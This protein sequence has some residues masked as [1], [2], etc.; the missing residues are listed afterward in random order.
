M[1][2]SFLNLTSSPK[3]KDNQW[4]ANCFML[5]SNNIA[6]AAYKS[7][8]LSSANW[9][10]TDTRIGGNVAIN[11]PPAYTRFADPRASGL[12]QKNVH[13]TRPA[14]L[15]EY[16]SDQIDANAQI[17]HMQFGV[18]TFRGMLSF[19]AGVS[20]IKAGL[21]ARTGRVPIAFYVGQVVGFVVGLR[22]LPFILAGKVIQFIMNRN[23]SRYYNL[24]PAMHP[25]WNRVNLI[26]NMIAVSEGLVD[27][28]AIDDL[29][30]GC[31][32]VVGAETKQS[33]SWR[34]L[35]FSGGEKSGNRFMDERH[36]RN[37]P[38]FC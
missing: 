30:D 24:K 8:M 13:G 10:F 22:L 6:P 5:S 11:M 19:F 1:A 18:P 33:G 20:D 3:I 16:W 36:K 21:L 25:Y 9:K 29:L 27:R 15:G 38:G 37:S 4:L 35:L 31:G 12:N 7:M 14:G 32:N 28:F 26:A 23:G 17:I 2:I 34:R